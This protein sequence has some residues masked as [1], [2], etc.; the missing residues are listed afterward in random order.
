MKVRPARLEDI[1]AIIALCAGFMAQASPLYQ[2]ITPNNDD[3]YAALARLIDVGV[4]L[5]AE[6]DDGKIVGDIG[7]S[8]VPFPCRHDM[9]FL[10]ENW[11]HVD[12]SARSLGAGRMLLDA[13]E[14][15]AKEK[16][17]AGCSLTALNN[18]SAELV[19]KA[20]QKR[21][22]ELTEF[23]FAKVF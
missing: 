4:L 12:E 6:T 21:G 17:C 16:G 7:G 18:D 13:F 3:F 23:V 19:G 2:A 20:Y 9:V 5:V 11:W 8:L 14:A 15:A 1:D 10:V 22:Y